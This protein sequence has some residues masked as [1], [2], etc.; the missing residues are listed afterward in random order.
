MTKKQTAVQ[1]LVE[2]ILVDLE[3]Y[4]NE[5]NDFDLSKD[6]KIKYYNA[7]MDSVDLSEYVN[8][9]IEMEK[10]QIEIA[11]AKSYLIGLAEVNYDDVNKASE[12][13]YN[14]TYAKNN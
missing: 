1:W 13:Y 7:F 11:F 8:K 14:E 12:Q 6:P 5:E 2:Q 9:A 4:F 3:D 10:E